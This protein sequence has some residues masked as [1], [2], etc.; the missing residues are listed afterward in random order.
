MGTQELWAT[1]CHPLPAVPYRTHR[2]RAI[3]WRAFAIAAA[4]IV[5]S[6]TLAGLSH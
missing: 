1:V 4:L 2:R 5:I 6:G 3:F